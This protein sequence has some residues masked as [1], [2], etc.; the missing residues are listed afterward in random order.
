MGNELDQR[1]VDYLLATR[2]T[3]GVVNSRVVISTAIGV[4]QVL[5]PSLLQVNGGFLGPDS[6]A[7]AKSLLSR[8]NFSKRKG[9]KTAKKVPDNLDDLHR[10]FVKDIK[11]TMEKEKIPKEMVINFDETGVPIVPQSQWTM[12]E[13][14]AKQVPL[15]ALDDK[16]QITAVL[17]CSMSG[18]LLPP[19]LLYQGTTERCHPK[20]T[21][22]PS[23]DIWHSPSHWSNH[24]TIVRYIEKILVPYLNQQRQEAALAFDHPAI[25]IL[26]VFKAHRTPDVLDV[27]RRSHCRLV[28][29][30]ANC[31]SEM[32]V[33]N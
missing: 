33:I 3:G 30:P 31:T 15:T 28:F 4:A 5:Q 13:Q 10:R 8:M 29:V 26:D 18:K 9:T 17:A 16:R 7:F 14:G 32:Q 23:W 6:K 12:A 24:N 1:V 25:V 22:P 27:F 11:D 21:V 19:Q 2:E 20:V